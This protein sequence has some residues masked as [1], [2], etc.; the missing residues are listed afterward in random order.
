MSIDR[1]I[2]LEPD[3][4]GHAVGRDPSR[5][6]AAEFKALGHEPKSPLAALRARCV[7]CCSGSA[8]EVRLCVAVT[9][10]AWPFRLGRNPYRAPSSE[11]Q[12]EASRRNAAKLHG[13]PAEAVKGTGAGTDL[14]SSEP[15]DTR[16]PTIVNATDL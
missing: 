3:E 5:M 12:R 6:I 4:G 2:G 13:A 16:R 9:C 7:D 8:H 11:A 15:D 14:P 10:A 1:S